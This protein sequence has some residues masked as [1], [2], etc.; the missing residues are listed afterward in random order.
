MVFRSFLL[1][2]FVCFDLANHCPGSFEDISPVWGC[3]LVTKPAFSG[4]EHFLS[5]GAASALQSPPADLVQVVS[6]HAKAHVALEPVPAFVRTTIQTMML[7]G[8]DVRL[9]GVVLAP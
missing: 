9:N 7:Q 4:T 2:G 8:V 3:S 1:T 6:Q 5:L